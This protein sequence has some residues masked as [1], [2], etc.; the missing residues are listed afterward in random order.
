MIGITDYSYHVHKTFLEGFFELAKRGKVPP[1]NKP[2]HLDGWGI[3]YYKN[4]RAGVIKS[5]K[6]VLKEKDRFFNALRKINRSKILIVHL[7]KSAWKNT[8]LVK[9]THP[10]KFN[11][12]IFCHNGTVL[13]YKPLIKEIKNEL[14]PGKG[15]LDSEV[16]FKY[17]LSQKGNGIKTKFK[18]TF[19]DIE[20]SLKHTSLTSLFSD[21][22]NLYAYLEFTKLPAYYTLFMSEYKNSSIVCSEPPVKNLKWK[23]LQKRKITAI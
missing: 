17:A 1:H 13:D 8:N 5:A 21:G 16:L 20:K 18:K 7:R 14:G 6:S 10:F 2:F 19:K 12:V 9:N 15:A 23:L 4:G 3:G 11:N 22:K